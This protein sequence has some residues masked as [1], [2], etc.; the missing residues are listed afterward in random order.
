MKLVIVESPAKCTTIKKYLGKE[1]EVIASK[2]HI[3]DLSTRG[4]GGLGVDVDKNFEPSYKVLPEKV[5]TVQELKSLVSKADEV[6]LATDPDREGEAISWHLATEL[7]LDINKT[8][9][10][11]FHEITRDSINAALESPRTID[12]NIVAA[13]E[14]RRIIDRIIGFKTSNLIYKKIKSPSAGRVQSATLKLIYDHD[15]EIESFVPEEYWNILV[16]ILI[17]NKEISLT[18]L[19]KNGKSFTVKDE[20]AANEILKQ[21]SNKMIISSINRDIR[22]KESKEP[23]TTSSLQQEAFAKLNFKT[24]KTQK[25]AQSL[26][27]GLSVNGEHTG[28][29]T[30]I[31][32]DS[33]RMAPAY[34]EKASAYIKE[35]YGNEYL[36]KPKAVKNQDNSQ[37]AHECIRPTSNH[38]TPESVR[39]YLT[40]DQYN[41]YKLIYNRALASLMKPKKEE[42]LVVTLKA[43]DYEY[44]FELVHTLFKGHE[45]IQHDSNSPKDYAGKFPELKVGDE[46]AVSNKNSEQKFTQAPAHYS[47]AKIVK[48]MEEKGIGRPSTYSTTIENLVDKKRKYAV[49]EKGLL[50]VTDQG[51]L[52]C[53]VLQKYFPSIVDTEYT[54]CMENILDKISTGEMTRLEALNNFYYPF[55]EM[56]KHATDTMYAEPPT[57]TGDVC[58]KCGAPLVYIEGKKGQF[59]GC[60]NYPNCD[61][62]QKDAKKE[63]VATDRLCPDCG[64]PLVERVNSKGKKFIACSNYPKCKYVESSDKKKPEVEMTNLVCPD[65]GAFL[66]KRKGPRGYF[67]GC[68]NYPKCKYLKKISWKERN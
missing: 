62:I 37:D 4:K 60:S 2:G 18:F 51:K 25:I 42:C 19:G 11:E 14:T 59:I 67:Y 16:N 46:L 44:K 50:T 53:K 64:S 15:L 43:G 33:T 58:P 9:R 40:P 8:K 41:L 48:L 29:I 61:Y 65:C 54:S 23:F 63:V 32:T 3:R 21:I 49:S 1:Y 6:I 7:G 47:E 28:L 5:K 68:S 26:Y 17:N 57:T 36:G 13:Q 22:L 66:V 27:E 39:Q 45:V 30:Y 56:L 35:V 20:A 24:S 52:T 31:R 10:L 38:R 55:L 34:I 12:M